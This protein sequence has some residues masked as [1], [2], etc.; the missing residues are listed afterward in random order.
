M[1]RSEELQKNLPVPVADGPCDH[2]LG[3][4]LPSL[5]LLPVHGGASRRVPARVGECRRESGGEK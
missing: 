5:E 3:M 1:Q 2:L 4:A